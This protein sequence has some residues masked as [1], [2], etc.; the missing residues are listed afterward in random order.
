MVKH[1]LTIGE[2]K[3]MDTRKNLGEGS[4]VFKAM[5]HTERWWRK[6]G[7]LLVFKKE[8]ELAL[9]EIKQPALLPPLESLRPETN[10]ALTTV[11]ILKEYH[12]K[13]RPNQTLQLSLF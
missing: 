11:S 7:W 6:K 5:R 10:I 9:E 13:F 3:P 8:I 12:F 1:G 4:G 2:L